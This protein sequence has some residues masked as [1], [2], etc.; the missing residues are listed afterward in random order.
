M[1][2][3]PSELTVVQLMVPFEQAL[4]EKKQQAEKAARQKQER[5]DA[6]KKAREYDRL[7]ASAVKA[8]AIAEFGRKPYNP[9]PRNSL[10]KN[11]IRKLKWIA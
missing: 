11:N 3:T 5:A 8:E 6:R 4:L 7:P 9:R 10:P 1:G 2:K